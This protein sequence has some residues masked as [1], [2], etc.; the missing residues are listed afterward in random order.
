[1]LEFTIRIAM[2]FEKQFCEKCNKLLYCVDT[3]SLETYRQVKQK[4]LCENCLGY[5]MMSWRKKDEIRAIMIKCGI[6]D[7]DVQR[8]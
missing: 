7:L 8:N 5:V 3:K 1:M 6:E 2:S 4:W